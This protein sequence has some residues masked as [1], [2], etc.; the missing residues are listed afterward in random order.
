MLL[1]LSPTL[2]SPNQVY[3]FKDDPL[4]IMKSTGQ[5]LID[6]HGTKY[7]DCINNVAHIGHCHP[8][9]SGALAKQLAEQ[10]TN[11]RYLHPS[12][13]ELASRIAHKTP[14][15]SNLTITYFVNSGS[16]AIDLALRLA[17]AYT[18]GEDVVAFEAA[19]H[20][21]LTST[22]AFSPYKYHHL[23]EELLKKHGLPAEWVHIAACPDPYRGKFRDT[24]VPKGEDV[25]AYLAKKYSEDLDNMITA[26]EKKGRKLAMFIAESI[27]SCG[28]QVVYPKGYLRQ[29]YDVIRK[30][31]G[32]CIADEVQCGFGRVGSAFWGF[33]LQEGATPDIIIV[34]KSMGN[35]YPVA[36][37]VTRPDIAEAFAN[38]WPE[39]FNTYGGNPV[40]A[41]AGLAVLDVL[42]D[43]KLM[44][45]A[46]KMGHLL[47]EKLTALANKYPKIIGQIRG[48][49]L[50][51]GIDIVED[52]EKRTP[53]KKL[54]LAIKSLLRT[55]HHVIVSTDGPY[56]NVIK[57]K[58]PM[59]FNADDVEN[60]VQSLDKV[61]A[62][63]FDN[64]EF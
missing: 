64:C 16:E 49:G 61:L 3:F 45:H 24:Q 15:N 5:Y 35:G 46:E 59:C 19:Y 27:Q 36:G 39:Y 41:A 10:A 38:N 60:L 17:R 21:T 55:K 62:T 8:H 18:G 63:F 26:A 53:N 13:A 25:D 2:H 57:I 4:L 51:F 1:T 52:V 42:E 28:G 43:E 9:W 11:V 12:V 56:D 40:S 58:P 7:L 37:V 29:A 6:E 23:S 50:M 33:E 34:G 30:H 44:E 20:G 14:E 54:A 47:R 48:E 32:V 22:T 31:G